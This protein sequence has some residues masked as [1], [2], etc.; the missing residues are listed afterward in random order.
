MFELYFSRQLCLNFTYHTYNS[1]LYTVT[2]LNNIKAI[3]DSIYHMP[4][5][6]FKDTVLPFHA[7]SSY[8][9]Y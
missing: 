2:P 4:I 6:L 5:I 3:E 7:P 8:N 9:I 1:R